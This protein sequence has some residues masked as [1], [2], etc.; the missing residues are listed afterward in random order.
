MKLLRRGY[1]I[2]SPFLWPSNAPALLQARLG[3]IRKR[4]NRDPDGRH[5]QSNAGTCQQQRSLCGAANERGTAGGAK[6][7][8]SRLLHVG[9]KNTAQIL[10]AFRRLG[11]GYWTLTGYVGIGSMFE[12]VHGATNGR[13]YVP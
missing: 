6:G 7:D 1:V 9:D 13:S 10:G 4:L 2:E 3:K 8:V 12:Q 5:D 11:E